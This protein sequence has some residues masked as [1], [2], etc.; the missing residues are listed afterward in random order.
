MDSMILHNKNYCLSLC[1]CRKFLNWIFWWSY[2]HNV[3]LLTCSVSY[4]LFLLWIYGKLNKISISI[5]NNILSVKEVLRL[6]LTKHYFLNLKCKLPICHYTN[7]SVDPLG[8]ACTS[9]G[10]HGSQFGNHQYM[11]ILDHS[12]EIRFKWFLCLRIEEE[13]VIFFELKLIVDCLMVFPISLVRDIRLLDN[14]RLMNWKEV[15]LTEHAV[16]AFDWRDWE[17]YESLCKDI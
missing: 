16:V 4:L 2:V 15:V 6:L 17:Y 9:L 7:V 12:R 5:W 14:L 11:Q 1:M 10:I 8:T 13:L 3:L